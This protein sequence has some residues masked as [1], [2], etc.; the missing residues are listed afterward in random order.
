MTPARKVAISLVASAAMLAAA[1]CLV[2]AQ[3]IYDALR[4]TGWAAFAT[5]GR[6]L[7]V[8]H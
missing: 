7:G 6:S 3:P 4:Q 8:I 5:V 1:I 2:G